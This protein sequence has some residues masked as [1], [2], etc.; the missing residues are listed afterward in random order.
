[1]PKHNVIQLAKARSVSYFLFFSLLILIASATRGQAAELV[2]IVPLSLPEKTV[3][4]LEFDKIIHFTSHEFLETPTT[5]K[6]CY[7][8]LDNTTRS[9]RVDQW[10][11]V[12]SPQVIKIRTGKHINKTRV[13]LDLNDD[14]YCRVSTQTEPFRI[15]METGLETAMNAKIPDTPLGIGTSDTPP[16]E[17]EKITTGE[18]FSASSSVTTSPENQHS[19]DDRQAE[20]PEL[21]TETADHPAERSA[22]ETAE[23]SAWG[24]LQ[25]YLTHD[26]EDDPYEDDKLN[27]QRAR[28]GI[29]WESNLSSQYS[30]QA[31]GSVDFDHLN[32]DDPRA[33]DASDVKLFD[34]YLQLNHTDWEISAGKQRVRWGKSD[35]LSPVDSINPQDLRQFITVDLEERK[36]PIWMARAKWFGESTAFE[37]IFNPW[38]EKNEFDYFDSDWALYRN[39]RKTITDDPLLPGTVRN[40]AAGIQV[41]ETEPSNSFKNSSAAARLT[42]VLDATDFGLSYRYGWETQP[43][44]LSFPVKNITY[45]GENTNPAQLLAGATLTSENV[46]ATFKRQQVIGFEWET[47]FDLVG[48]RGE[49]AHFDQVAFLTTNL[50]SLRKP[51]THLVTGIDYTS[52]DEWYFNLQ[53]SWYKIH[54]FEQRI[55]YLEEDNLSVLGEIRKPVWQGNLEL[56]AKYNYSIS[57]QSSYLQPSVKLKYFHNLECEVGAVIFSGDKDTLLGSYDQA[58][59]GYARIKYFF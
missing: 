47:V 7:V 11:N 35:Q 55:I 36:I 41:H 10:I 19:L 5:L 18:K 46:E 20:P 9:K 44:I 57:D 8:D 40:Y 49:I 51:T 59:Q 26:I 54:D 17:P 48:F 37:A 34:T 53:A 4:T 38:L 21:T 56:S 29:D 22:I 52:N 32:Y 24:W 6:R 14:V 1:M 33:D 25:G 16:V 43:T 13:V 27:R 42:W 30:L 12:N 2:D 23:F 31:R 39:L 45:T 58:D 3:V 50:T 15:I 28:L